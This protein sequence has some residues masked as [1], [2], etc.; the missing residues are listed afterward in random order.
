MAQAVKSAA[1]LSRRKTLRRFPPGMRRISASKSKTASWRLPDLGA[2]P[3]AGAA[4]CRDGFC[5][6]ALPY[7]ETDC[8]TCL[9]RTIDLSDVVL[10]A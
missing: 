2:E 10:R 5:F 4:Y 7:C 6:G 3:S 8:G 1:S 9:T